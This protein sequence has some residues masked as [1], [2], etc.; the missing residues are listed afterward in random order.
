MQFETLR[1]AALRLV[2]KLSGV[3]GR[4]ARPSLQDKRFAGGRPFVIYDCALL[5]C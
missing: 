4:P 2:V 3:E 5:Y 1:S